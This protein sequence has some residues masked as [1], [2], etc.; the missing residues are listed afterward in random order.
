MTLLYLLIFIVLLCFG[1][2]KIAFILVGVT[3]LVDFLIATLRVGASATLEEGVFSLTV[4]AGPVKL[5]LLP[6]GEKK[7]AKPGKEKPGKKAKKQ[8]KPKEEKE[9]GEKK[10]KPKIEISFELISTVLS[11]VGELLGRLRR[12]IRIDRLTVHYTAA[13]DDPA[14]AAM[15]FGY[16]SAGVN[17]LMPAVENIFRVKERDVGVS[18][19][20]DTDE[21]KIYLDAQ[22]TLA[23]WE[24]L[25][26]VL[27]VW[28][29]VKAILGQMTNKGK[30]DKNGQASDQ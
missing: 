6:K 28:P 2:F 11:A 26:I 13:S 19:A 15:T 1:K 20:F 29:P 21:S 30:V 16:A 18:V 10:P 12:K 27:A 4:L 14:K 3:L 22:L 8:K 5:K 24:I 7:P 25:Y 23:I 17:A 9:T